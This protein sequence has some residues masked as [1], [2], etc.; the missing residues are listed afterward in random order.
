MT[1]PKT[2]VEKLESR[3]AKVSDEHSALIATRWKWREIRVRVTELWDLIDHLCGMCNLA[4]TRRNSAD[5]S[6]KRC[7]YCPTQVMEFCRGLQKKTTEIEA[8]FDEEIDCV[9]A[10]LSGLNEKKLADDKGSGSGV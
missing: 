5:I 6:V 3:N 9:I 1:K 7:N 8:L 4:M 2:S 10:F